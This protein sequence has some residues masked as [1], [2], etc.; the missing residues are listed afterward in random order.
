[1]TTV[2]RRTWRALIVSMFLLGLAACGSNGDSDGSASTDVGL[3]STPTTAPTSSTSGVTTTAP[4]ARSVVRAYLLRD[5]KVGPVAREVTGRAVAAGAMEALLAGPT[6]AERELGFASTIPTGTQLLGVRVASGVA[7]VDLSAEFASGGGSL[8]MMGRAAQVVY[9]LT[10]FPSVQSVAFELEGEPLTE[11]GGEGLLLTEPQTR[12]AWEAFTPAIMVESPLPFAEVASPLRITGTANTFE[13]SFV[14]TVT[15]GDGLIVYERPAMATSGTGTRG[16]FDVTAT[17]DVPRAGVGA[18]IVF[19][20]SPMDGSRIDL[21][22][23][24]VRL[25]G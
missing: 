11:L 16:T 4:A 6:D 18:V 15:D 23:V 9:T 19:A 14:V 21:L 2:H 22:E 24:P 12:A 1:M 8:S 5:E 3:T 13:A 25:N 7:T 10:Q 17:F 20:E